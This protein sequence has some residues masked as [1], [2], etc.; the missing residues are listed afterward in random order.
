MSSSSATATASRS[1]SPATPETSDCS[2]YN[3]VAIQNGF[4]LSPWYH[5]P[6]PEKPASNGIAWDHDGAPHIAVEKGEEQPMLQFDDLIEEHAYD[7]YV[8]G[9]ILIGITP[10]D[11]F[12]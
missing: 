1:P 10:N 12:P 11:I 4:E 8:S 7:E 3:P 5:S 9:Y 2:S 6:H